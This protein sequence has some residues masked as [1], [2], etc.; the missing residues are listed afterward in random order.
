MQITVLEYPTAIRNIH[1][2][3][4][5]SKTFTCAWQRLNIEFVAH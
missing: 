4:Q 3:I 5:S 1:T 2:R